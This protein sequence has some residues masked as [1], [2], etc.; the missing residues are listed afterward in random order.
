[1]EDS[2][3]VPQMCVYIIIIIIQNRTN[4][5]RRLSLCWQMKAVNTWHSATQAHHYT[6]PT[7]QLT[8]L[9]YR[10]TGLAHSWPHRPSTLTARHI[11]IYS[12]L[13]AF[14]R[15]SCSHILRTHRRYAR[16]EASALLGYYAASSGNSLPTFRDNLSV[17]YSRVENPSITQR[18]VVIN[19]RRFGTTYR[20]HIQGPRIILLSSV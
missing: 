13:W 8:C 19:Y 11:S 12:S 16:F 1:M 20:S 15:V 14:Q 6:W 2:C 4:T 7:G 18:V 5:K 10:V 9:T 17:P 3:D